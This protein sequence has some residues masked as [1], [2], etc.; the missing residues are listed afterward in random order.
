MRV[1]YSNDVDADHWDFIGTPLMSPQEELAAAEE[2]DRT[3][4]RLAAAQAAGRSP[5][6]SSRRAAEIARLR[7]E[8]QAACRRFMLPKL[9]LVV[10]IAKQYGSGR[11]ELLDLIQEGVLGLIRAVEKFDHT[12]GCK[13]STYAFWWIRQAVMKANVHFRGASRGVEAAAEK[14]RKVR[15]AADRLCQV[16]RFKP[17]TSQTAEEVGMPVNTLEE[18]LRMERPPASL[19]CPCSEDD[20]HQMAELV[21]DH[22]EEDPSKRIDRELLQQRFAGILRTLNVHERQVIRLRF[23]LADG[24]PLSLGDI[25]K[26]M[27]LSRE[28]IRQIEENTMRK[29]RQ[30]SRAA[31]LVGFFDEPAATLM[32]SAAELQRC[33]TD[34]LLRRLQARRARDRATF[35]LPALNAEE[36]T[37]CRDRKSNPDA[38]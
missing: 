32:K 8:Y 4:R 27:H 37:I 29:L 31:Q 25:G 35:R 13:F 12:R 2:V 30:P 16:N 26:I 17:N 10:S 18:L 15:I 19:D 34:T 24:Q 20:P 7:Q 9:R 14:L 28:R 36:E 11:Q 5:R 6:P 21:C 22:R 23:G 3:R 38:A 1:N 33:I